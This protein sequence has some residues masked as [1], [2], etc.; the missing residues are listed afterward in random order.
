[1]ESLSWPSINQS[2]NQSNAAVQS[3]YLAVVAASAVILIISSVYLVD[4]G[5]IYCMHRPIHH[6]TTRGAVF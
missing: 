3:A 4:L 1:M 5:D 6:E 2:I